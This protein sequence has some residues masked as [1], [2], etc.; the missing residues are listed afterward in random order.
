MRTTWSRATEP[1][2]RRY[3]S[4]SDKPHGSLM[5][6]TSTEPADSSRAL[7][8]ASETHAEPPTTFVASPQR[9]IGVCLLTV[10]MHRSHDLA[11]GRVRGR[12]RTGEREPDVQS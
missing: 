11:L 5:E 10:S 1:S 8:F 7:T 4:P 6:T 2:S 12:V 3:R 9:N